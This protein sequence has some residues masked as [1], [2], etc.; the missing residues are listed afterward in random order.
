MRLCSTTIKVKGDAELN[1]ALFRVMIKQNGKK[2]A[3]L[4]SGIILYEGLLTWVY[5]VI[6]K[7]PAVSQIA[8]SLPSA[9]KTVFGVSEEARVDTFE[10]FITAQFFAR[11]WAMLLA[12]Y[13]VETANELLAAMAND[14]SLALLLSTPV[15]RDE[16]LTTQALVLFSGNALLI[17]FTLLGLFVGTKR[18]GINLDLW[19]YCIFSIQG[20]AFYSLIG[21]YSLLFSALFTEGDTAFTMAAS[22]TLA[23]YALDVAGGLSDQLSWVRKLSLFRC[24]QP[25]EVLEG[26]KNPA[27]ETIGLIAGTLILLR[28]GIYAFNKKDLA[29]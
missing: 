15:S 27:K 18:F 1:D 7:N 10:A 6:S 16:F 13:N 22:L 24:Y 23:F 2:I 21:A 14:G 8:G 19:R 25:Q 5:P 9:V 20:F 29:I 26:S 11:I 17:F 4:S 12:L 3:K 28:L